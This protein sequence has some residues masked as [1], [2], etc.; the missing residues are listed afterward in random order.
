[1]TATGDGKLPINIIIIIRL[2]LLLRS[3]SRRF[4]FIFL[5]LIDL[6]KDGNALPSTTGNIL[7]ILYVYSFFSSAK[8]I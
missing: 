5:C 8:C 7:P 1:M 3:R 2:L 4:V 6:Q